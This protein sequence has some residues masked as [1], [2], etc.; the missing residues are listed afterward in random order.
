MKASVIIK[1]NGLKA[2][3]KRLRDEKWSLTVGVHGA[4]GGELAHG[5]QKTTILDIATW[6]EYGMGVPERSFIRDWADGNEARNSQ[7]LTKI[8]TE[9]LKGAYTVEVGLLRL[10]ALFKGEIQSRISQGISPPN[11]DITIKLKGSSTPL[12]DDGQL[13][14][15]IMAKVGKGDTEND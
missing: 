1:D 8:A 14:S 15:S 10:G 13:R 2:L 9:V 12:I 6:N 5:E 11:A 4:E 7:R 3:M